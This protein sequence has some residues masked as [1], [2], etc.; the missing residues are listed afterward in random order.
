M[1]CRFDV[2]DV[3]TSFVREFPN[4]MKAIMRVGS[5]HVCPI[6]RKGE[7]FPDELQRGRGVGGENYRVFRR[8]AEE[9]KYAFTGLSDRK[10]V[11]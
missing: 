4:S 11:V 6:L 10:S 5:E 1:G 3:G 2:F 7:G 8:G 9:R